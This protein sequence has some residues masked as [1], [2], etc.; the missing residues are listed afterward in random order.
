MAERLS[1][2]VW[3][4]AEPLASQVAFYV[5]RPASI[6]KVED[7]PA[8]DAKHANNTKHDGKP[9]LKPFR[10]GE[11]LKTSRGAS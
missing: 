6:V 1:T 8:K 3:L 4:P 7:F 11:K 5:R 10:Q 9:V 2:P